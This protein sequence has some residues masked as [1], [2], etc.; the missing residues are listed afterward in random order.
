M[1]D[2]L[3]IN[4]LKRIVTYNVMDYINQGYVI[5]YAYQDSGFPAVVLHGYDKGDVVKIYVQY[6]HKCDNN[7]NFIYKLTT[8]SGTYVDGLTYHRDNIYEK[9][10]RVQD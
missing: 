4:D 8:E 1:N 9:D 3:G 10:F 7:D 6:T 5:N 2:V